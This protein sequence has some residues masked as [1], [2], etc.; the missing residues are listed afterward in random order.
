MVDLGI[1][2]ESAFVFRVFVNICEFF[3]HQIVGQCVK[4]LLGFFFG[5][6]SGMLI[7]H[8][9]DKHCC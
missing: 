2:V 1:W 5:H 4:N 7:I 9:P 6:L 8:C 3:S